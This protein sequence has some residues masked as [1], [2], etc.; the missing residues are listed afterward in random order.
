MGAADRAVGAAVADALAEYDF[1]RMVGALVR[2]EF[3]AEFFD[4]PRSSQLAFVDALL[5]SIKS[6]LQGVDGTDE[7]LRQIGRPLFGRHL[8]KKLRELRGDGTAP[9]ALDG[10][11]ET[12]DDSLSG[13]GAAPYTPRDL[14]TVEGPGD[15]GAGF[16]DT[17][18]PVSD[19]RI[20]VE[21]G[22]LFWWVI[23]IYRGAEVGPL[24]TSH[25]TFTDAWDRVRELLE[26]G[27]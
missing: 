23:A 7:A 3:L 20:R 22:F 1:Q 15:T 27:Q 14:P 16:D 11:D 5:Y 26:V 19:S 4:Q 6:L 21:R 9:L 13:S 17:P 18:A 10:T 2:A 12:H 25:P 24:T 8:L